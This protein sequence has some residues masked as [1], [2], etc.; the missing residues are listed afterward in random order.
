M[1]C[2]QNFIGINTTLSP[3]SAKYLTDIDVLDSYLAGIVITPELVAQM[4]S[5]I[6]LAIKETIEDLSQKLFK[7]FVINN[8]FMEIQTPQLPISFEALNLSGI[9]GV[10]IRLKNLSLGTLQ[11]NS[12]RL[13]LKAKSSSTDVL[14]L[15]ITTQE[16]TIQYPVLISTQEN[17]YTPNLE[18]FTIGDFIRI[19]YQADDVVVGKVDKPKTSSCQSCGGGISLQANKYYSVFNRNGDTDFAGLI[20][21]FM[22]GC[23][24]D[25]VF[26]KLKKSLELPMLYA[27][28]I[29]VI[30]QWRYVLGSPKTSFRNN[31]EIVPWLKQWQQNYDKS[32]ALTL[33]Q[34][35]Y[36]LQSIHYQSPCISCSGRR[37]LEG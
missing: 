24:L 17:L 11:L 12:L 28:A 26:C 23:S 19:E 13:W 18:V 9:Q 15:N 27:S 25:S 3:N 37:Y 14:V 31:E 7:Y 2:F 21:S 29:K 35:R 30:S 1:N 4:Q 34:A 20:P 22:I 6:K 16:E 8:P 5:S 33:Q 36:Y 32:L 10:E